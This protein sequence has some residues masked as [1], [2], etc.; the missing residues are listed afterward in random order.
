[1][2]PE[3]SVNGI[4]QDKAKA[5]SVLTINRGV[6][7]HSKVAPLWAICK[8]SKKPVLSFRAGAEGG[9]RI[10]PIRV[11]HKNEEFQ[12]GGLVGTVTAPSPKKSILSNLLKTGSR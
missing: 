9:N 3:V 8:R 10:P 5:K 2:N 1:M 7:Q 11:V 4:L 6:M 12:S